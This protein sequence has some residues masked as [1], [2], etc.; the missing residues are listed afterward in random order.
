VGYGRTGLWC[1]SFNFLLFFKIVFFYE[2][3]LTL[4]RLPLPHC[5]VVG[6]HIYRHFQQLIVYDV[7]KCVM[8]TRTAFSVLLGGLFPNLTLYS[9]RLDIIISPVMLT[10]L[11]AILQFVPQNLNTSPIIPTCILSHNCCCVSNQIK[12]FIHQIPTIKA[13]DVAPYI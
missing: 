5:F 9:S 10:M 12:S 8:L 6:T 3:L 7:I 1:Y 2:H 11:A 13:T 4:R